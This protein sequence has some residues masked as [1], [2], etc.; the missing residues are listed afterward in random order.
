MMLVKCNPGCLTFCIP[1]LLDKCLPTVSNCKLPLA[2]V[3]LTFSYSHKGA[4]LFEIL[5]SAAVI[6]NGLR[7]AE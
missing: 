7:L 4:T 3:A 1:L 2:P 6:K 5:F